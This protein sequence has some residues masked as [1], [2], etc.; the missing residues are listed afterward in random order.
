MSCSSSV[1]RWSR[2]RRRRTG[3]LI[4]GRP[5]GSIGVAGC[6][7]FYPTKNLGAFGDARRGCDL[8]PGAGRRGSRA[9]RVRGASPATSPAG[10]G[11]TRDWTSFR[12]RSSGS[13]LRRLEADN[14]RRAEIAGGL[15]PRAGTDE[16]GRR[17][18]PVRRAL[19]RARPASLAARGGRHRDRRPLPWAISEQPA[20]EAARRG[21]ALAASTGR[22]PRGAV[23]SLLPAPDRGGAGQRRRSPKLG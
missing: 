4:D 6:F 20:F 7:S 9:P 23:A 8:G 3:S 16:P 22:G 19:E 2:T 5:A 18:P 14:R 1:C 21:D 12:P 13:G 11:Q 10:W 15:R 17:S